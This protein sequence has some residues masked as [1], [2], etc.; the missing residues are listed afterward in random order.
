MRNL[1][2][3]TATYGRTIA[4]HSKHYIATPMR[5]AFRRPLRPT[6]SSGEH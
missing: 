5:K 4:C 1:S 3:D 2:T 6:N